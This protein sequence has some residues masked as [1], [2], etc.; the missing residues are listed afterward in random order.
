MTGR[1]GRK[2]RQL[3]DDVK[4]SRGYCNSKEEAVLLL[5]LLLLLFLIAA[6]GLTPS[7]ISTSS[8]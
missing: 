1:Q 6:I 3:P 2:R 7:G 4:E 5:L 8:N